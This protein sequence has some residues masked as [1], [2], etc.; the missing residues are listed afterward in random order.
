MT[1]GLIGWMW[2]WGAVVF[3]EHAKSI[4][5]VSNFVKGFV[6]LFWP[7]MVPAAFLSHLVPG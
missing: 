6:S 2:F 5:N 3:W 4:G 1:W 7:I